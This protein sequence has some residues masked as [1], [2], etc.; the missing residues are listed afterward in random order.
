MPD[1]P[2]LELERLAG[3]FVHLA[4]GKYVSGKHWEKEIRNGKICDCF[5]GGN[6]KELA[7]RF[8]LS[9]RQIRRLL[10]KK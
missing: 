10:K 3:I 7:G 6:Y 2:L 8:G 4:A 9:T 1:L 5:A